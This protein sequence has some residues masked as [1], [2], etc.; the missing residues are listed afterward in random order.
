MLAVGV[1]ATAR[2]LTEVVGKGFESARHLA[3]YAG[4]APLTWRP[5]IS[6]ERDHS[7]RRGDKILKRASFLSAFAALKTRCRGVLRQETIQ[8]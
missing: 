3:S 6:I 5:R 1:R 4:L 8:A 7:S 2:I